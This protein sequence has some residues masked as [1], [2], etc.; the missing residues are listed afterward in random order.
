MCTRDVIFA[1]KRALS[2]VKFVSFAVIAFRECGN[3]KD[4]KHFDNDIIIVAK[5]KIMLNNIETK[6]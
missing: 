3:S 2:A 6:H 5:M 1:P 4:T